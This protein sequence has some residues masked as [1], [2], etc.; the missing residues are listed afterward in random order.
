MAILN[1]AMVKV[2]N[3]VGLSGAPI[4][5]EGIAGVIHPRIYPGRDIKT[6]TGGSVAPDDF[7]IPLPPH[8][9][10]SVPFFPSAYARWVKATFKS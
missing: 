7:M 8:C 9:H 5:F 3:M 4:A 2:E 1:S 10:R 6:E